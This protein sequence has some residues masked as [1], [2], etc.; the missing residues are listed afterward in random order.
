MLCTPINPTPVSCALFI[1]S[2]IDWW[3]T[4]CP[5]LLFPLISAIEGVSFS[6]VMVPSVFITCAS[7]PCMYCGNLPIPCDPNP[8]RSESIVIS[9]ILPASSVGTPIFVRISVISVFASMGF[10]VVLFFIFIQLSKLILLFFYYL[11]IVGYK[12]Y[13]LL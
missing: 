10:I 5:N 6:I 4:S 1:A 13:F 12:Y 9:A 2:C 3:A 8:F 11:F 7:I